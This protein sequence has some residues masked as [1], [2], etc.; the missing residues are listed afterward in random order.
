MSENCNFIDRDLFIDND[1]ET[2]SEVREIRDIDDVMLYYVDNNLLQGARLCIE[3]TITLKNALSYIV[4]DAKIAD[5][6]PNDL[7]FSPDEHL[8]TTYATNDDYGWHIENINGK[9]YPVTSISQSSAIRA[10]DGKRYI[11]TNGERYIKVVL[12]K[13]LTTKGLEDAINN[14]V[15]ICEYS[16]NGNRRMTKEIQ[17]ASS[18]NYLQLHPADHDDQGYDYNI[19]GSVTI[20]PPTG[21]GISYKRMELVV[22]VFVMFAS[23]VIFRKFNK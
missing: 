19:S 17:A 2:K 5:Y 13:A 7:T 15:E 14:E 9:S 8:I 18:I 6:L 22:A 11:G 3:Y 1:D 23:V 10:I 21:V 20:I 12:S 16:N 4:T